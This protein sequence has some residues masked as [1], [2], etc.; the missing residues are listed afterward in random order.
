MDD[1][2]RVTLLVPSSRLREPVRCVDC[3]PLCDWCCGEA[4]CC[5]LVLRFLYTVFICVTP[6]DSDD[7][8]P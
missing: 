4:G 2:D 5:V 6:E 8:V 1:P 3:G 7:I